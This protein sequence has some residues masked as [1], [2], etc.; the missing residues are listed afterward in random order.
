MQRVTGIGG[1]FIKSKDPNALREWYRKHL[2]IE[3]ESWGGF[4]FQW[5]DDPRA[6]NGST[7]W[8]IFPDSSKYFAPADK[9]F[10][11]NFRVEDLDALLLALREEGVE[12]IDKTEVS[13]FGRFGWIV[14]CD[15][16]RVELW[17][18]PAGA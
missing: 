14:D 6:D 8:S 1:I 11:I 7:I 5:K 16:R 2:G 9:P 15:G 17:Q 13:E 3:S 10:M 4:A 12:V 18:P